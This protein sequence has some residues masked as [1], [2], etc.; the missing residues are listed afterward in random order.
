MGA[1]AQTMPEEVFTPELIKSNEPLSTLTDEQINAFIALG[2]NVT[3]ERIRVVTGEFYTGIDNDVVAET[4]LTKKH[5]E[6]TFDFV[7]RALSVG[8]KELSSQLNALK[9]EKTILEGQLGTGAGDAALRKQIEELNTQIKSKTSEVNQYKE[10][11]SKA[12]DEANKKLTEAEQKNI[13]IKVDHVLDKTISGFKFIDKSK[14]PE[15][16]RDATIKAARS[17]VLSEYTPEFITNEIGDESVVW[18]NADGPALN[19]ANGM[20]P[21][22]TAELLLKHLNPILDQGRTAT[23]AG[24]KPS[25]GGNNAQSFFLN[26]ESTQ[27]A[28]DESIG[29]FIVTQLGLARG[30]KE[31]EDK[32][33]AIRTENNVSKLPFN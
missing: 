25:T 12:L 1:I 14:L 5:G 3:K 4:G 16:A 23:G 19:P 26:G 15:V 32:L 21:Y 33:N 7:K 24:T 11:Y 29:N 31:F 10:Q 30:T 13:K 9:E 18:S 2:N 17:A 20:K 6:R 27:V 28:A 22:T 8:N